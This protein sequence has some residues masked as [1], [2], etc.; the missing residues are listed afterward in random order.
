MPT[1]VPYVADGGISGGPSARKSLAYL[2]LAE[3]TDSTGNSTVMQARYIR[4]RLPVNSSRRVSRRVRLGMASL[5]GRLETSGGDR[6]V[7]VRHPAL[8]C[9]GGRGR[10]GTHRVPAGGE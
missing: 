1:M 3:S 7:R 9:I 2:W 5:S 4:T 10:A 6:L 8:V